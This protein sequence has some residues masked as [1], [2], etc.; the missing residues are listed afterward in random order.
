[1]VKIGLN[2]SICL[3][4]SIFW[5]GLFCGF[6]RVF[7]NIQP[8]VHTKNDQNTC[9]W[10]FWQL[11]VTKDTVFNSGADWWVG[12]ISHPQNSKIVI[13]GGWDL[14]TTI[15]IFMINQYLKMEK[16]E[17]DR[18][19]GH[20]LTFGSRCISVLYKTLIHLKIG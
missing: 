1:M 14:K 13:F 20:F 5:I 17:N 9:F 11:D 7:C 10:S 12:P 15:S 16:S 2:R 3:S 19:T 18:F 8:G 6:F 4:L